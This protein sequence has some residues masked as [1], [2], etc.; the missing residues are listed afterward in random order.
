MVLA[1]G[2]N[3]V[4]KKYNPE[5]LIDLATLTG[6]VVRTFGYSAAGMFTNNQE[7][8]NTMSA[9]GYKVHERV[10]QYHYLKIMKQI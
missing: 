9:I 5:Y 4:I 10:W 1:D 2:I 3:Y 8:A 7:M 6:S